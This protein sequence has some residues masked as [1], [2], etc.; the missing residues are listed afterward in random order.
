MQTY[1]IIDE[2]K[3]RMAAHLVVNPVMILLVAIIVPLFGHL[4]LMA[5][6]WLP[7]LWILGNGYLLG[8]P[9]WRKEVLVVLGGVAVYFSVLFLSYY[10]QA[11][12][13][14]FPNDGMMI[15][16]LRIVLQAVFFTVLYYVVFL[17]TA[18]FALF[19]YIR[20]HSRK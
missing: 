19:D 20:S 18:P 6:Y 2:P 17:Q 3:A 11:R 5:Q 4:P 16:Y 1:Q 7:L 10:L 8:S 13:Q 14:L 12:F 9:S 15:P